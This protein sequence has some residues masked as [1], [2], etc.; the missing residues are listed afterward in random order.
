MKYLVKLLSILLLPFVLSGCDF[1]DEAQRLAT[2]HPPLKDWVRQDLGLHWSAFLLSNKR[3]NNEVLYGMLKEID[4][5]GGDADPFRRKIAD[6]PRLRAQIPRLY[7]YVEI[8]RLRRDLRL[9]SI[10][11]SGGRIAFAQHHNFHMSFIGYTEGLSDARNE[12]TFSPDS[13]LSLIDLR[14]GQ[15]GSK[16]DLLSDKHGV[17]R[18]V[19]VSADGNRLLFSWKQSDRKDDYHIYEYDLRADTVTQLTYGLG[20]ADI[21]PQYL[22]DGDIIF[23]STRGEHSVPCYYT[24]VTNLYRMDGQGRYMRRLAVDQVH[25]LYPTVLENGRV[26]YTRWDYNDR[27]QVYP[28]PL[29]SM[30]PDGTGQ[31]VYYGGNSWFPNS[32]I[33][34]RGIP[35]T[36]RVMAVISGHHTL[37]R[38]KLVEIDVS[39]GRDEGL[40]MSFIAPQRKVQYERVDKAMQHGEHFKYPFPINSNE[41]L[42]SYTPDHF[43]NPLGGT[44]L[45]GELAVYGLYWMDRDGKRELL[46][47]HD[48][49]S[50]GRMV[51]LDNPSRPQLIPNAVDYRKKTGTLYVSNVYE[52]VGLKGIPYGTA[53][54]IRVVQLNYRAAGVGEVHN[55]ADEP[56]GGSSINSTPVAIGQGTWDVKQILGDVDIEE[57]GSALFEIPAMA[58]TYL[59]ILDNK[60]QVIQTTRSWDT[61]QPG[62][63]KAC[64][65]C[66]SKENSNFYEYAP[67]NTIAWTKPPQT[68]QP[69]YGES[70]GFSFIKEIQPILDA[71]CISCHGAGS[72]NGS[73]DGE[74]KRRWTLGK[75]RWS[76]AYL[77]LTNAKK[78]VAFVGASSVPFPVGTY[79]QGDHKNDLVNW[80]S[81]MSAPTELPP[82]YAGSATSKLLPWLESGEHYNVTLTDEEYHK[83]AAWIDLLV[84]FVGDYKEANEWTPGDL[85]FYEYY[86]NK[87][88]ENALEEEANIK[89]LLK[90]Q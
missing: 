39:E 52:G 77:T 22:P 7:L 1:N 29:F 61:I 48:E 72:R 36:D 45:A 90:S 47:Q 71:K 51:L 57:D 25:T 43:P 21:E 14:Q 35:G 65:G 42:V 13:R 26:I 10:M 68:L 58:S 63:K 56:E 3:L 83:F 28:H 88:H 66:H 74:L 44:P 20:R 86:E 84:P 12:R 64:R 46:Y 17:I 16:T 30:N 62:E 76:D 5:R 81:K 23:A 53:K 31:R 27:G 38:G 69:F 50:V 54:K 41:F 80:I 73:L 49:I 2:I 32:L 78:V 40:G 59:Q 85:G 34:A 60:G 8:A 89:A 37:Q 24:E 11:A 79:Y 67:E 19:D 33:H 75:R 55:H 18:D 9:K 70:R 4:R 15:Y 82:Y 87:R 6:I